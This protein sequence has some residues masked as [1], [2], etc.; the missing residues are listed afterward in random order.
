MNAFFDELS[1][2]APVPLWVPTAI[3]LLGWVLGF[4]AGF[5][6]RHMTPDE[7]KE[8]AERFLGAAQ[9]R[10]FEGYERA[11]R[12]IARG[13]GRAAWMADEALG[14]GPFWRGKPMSYF[15][16]LWARFKAFVK[17]GPRP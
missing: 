10:S 6:L 14:T 3:A 9:R 16:Y 5:W 1:Q 17:Y 11:L 2:V 4:A 12:K 8:V 7:A 13:W 15:G